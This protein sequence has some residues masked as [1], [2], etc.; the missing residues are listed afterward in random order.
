M[1]YQIV[2][3]LLEVAAGLVG[4]ACLL[5]FYMQLLRVPMSR[6][7]GNPVAPA[8]FA[9]SDWLVLPLRRVVPALGGFDM[10]SLL[11]A[12]A[13]ELGQF[14]LL[15]LLAGSSGGLFAVPILAVFGLARLAVM[16]L[17]VITVLAA[18]LS[19]VAPYAP[20]ADLVDRLSAPLLAPLRRF[21]PLLGGLDLTP[22][23]L[24]V[25]LQIAA[26]VLGHAQAAVLLMA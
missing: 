14:G 13:L 15:W 3:L 8:V 9:L 7:S 25:A 26:I 17:T 18:V 24:L 10:A 21:I 23:V 1:L 22:L 12:L 20:M 16:G 11:G 4:G 5:R 19:W 2:A 6:R